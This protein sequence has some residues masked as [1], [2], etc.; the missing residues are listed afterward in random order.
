MKI[1]AISDTHSMHRK[2]DPLPEGDILIHAGDITSRGT[3]FEVQEFLEWFKDQ[4]FLFKIF[5]AGNHDWLFERNPK[6]ASSILDNYPSITYLENSS[7]IIEG[8]KIY[9]TPIVPVFFDW[10]FNREIKDRE[11]YYSQIPEDTDILVTHNPPYK[12]LDFANYKSQHAG[13]SAL[14]ARVNIV[15]PKIHLFG[16]I[17]EAYGTYRGMNTDFYNC[18]QL[19]EQYR[20]ANKPHIIDYND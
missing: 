10:A 4:P 14:N 11:A 15:K 2:L 17:H 20:I 7:M 13:C 12:I 6:I 19:N 1:V 3:I 9:G 5:I 18:A 8:I 16:D